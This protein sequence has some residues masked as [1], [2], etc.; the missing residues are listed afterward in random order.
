MSA[1]DTPKTENPVAQAVQENLD[2]SRKIWLAGVGAYGRCQA[3]A[4][5]KVE[6]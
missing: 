4:L 5:A 2:L 3:P 1:E 6:Q